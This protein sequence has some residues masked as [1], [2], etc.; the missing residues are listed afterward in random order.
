MGSFKEFYLLEKKKSHFQVLKD[1]KIP[2]T[3]EERKE[4]MDAKCCWHP[5]NHDH[6]TCAIWKGKDS[7]GKIFFVCNTYRCFQTSPTL[8]GAIKNF[9]FV[10]TT[11]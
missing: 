9:E 6:P 4:A 10:K 1:N 8:K 2:L 11:A 5:G 7:S 3:P